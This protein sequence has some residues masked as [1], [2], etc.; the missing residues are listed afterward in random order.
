[1]GIFDGIEKLINEHGSAQILGERLLLASDQNAAQERRISE[2]ERQL[3]ESE[4]ERTALRNQLQ[5][6]QSEH[7][8]AAQHIQSIHSLPQLQFVA[9][10]YFADGDAVPFCP[11]CWEDMKKPIHLPPPFKSMA[12]SVYKCHKCGKSIVHPRR[13]SSS[14]CMTA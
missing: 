10:F 11:T 8:Q 4:A 2:L 13:E 14:D 5:R 3:K 6:S 1:M 9:P 7:Q 12:G